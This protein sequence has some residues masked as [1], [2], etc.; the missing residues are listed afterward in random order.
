LSVVSTNHLQEQS[1]LYLSHYSL[2]FANKK[3]LEANIGTIIHSESSLSS[4]NSFGP[5]SNFFHTNDSPREET[6]TSPKRHRFSLIKRSSSS[7]KTVQSKTEQ[8]D[9][10]RNSMKSPGTQTPLSE[11]S[12]RISSTT[13][14]TKY[15]MKSSPAPQTP[16]TPTP[17]TPES[18][19]TPVI[20]KSSFLS[21]KNSRTFSIFKKKTEEIPALVRSHSDNLM[22][23]LKDIDKRVLFK[24]YAKKEFSDENMRFW[25]DV[26]LFKSLEDLETKLDKMEEI[27]KN[28]LTNG[29][30]SEINIST[31]LVEVVKEQIFQNLLN[32][33][34]EDDKLFDS[35]ANDLIGG[36]LND[37]F[38]RFRFSESY[39]NLKLKE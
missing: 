29:A 20:S 31:K 23:I 26:Q 39:L 3:N 8:T 30:A 19:P 17:H 33:E 13:K 25:K 6:V 1:L 35:I 27:Q 36:I 4:L 18:S 2:I 37:T 14:R 34:I 15:S 24:E 7:L 38:S 22:R 10:P 9:S 12:P 32:N 11:L 28:Y 16:T 21:F 5:I